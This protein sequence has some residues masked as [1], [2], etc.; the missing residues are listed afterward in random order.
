MGLAPS[1]ETEIYVNTLDQ[2]EGRVCRSVGSFLEPL[3]WS[4]RLF[5]W[6]LVE[7]NV[8]FLL[9][10]RW[11]HFYLSSGEGSLE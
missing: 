1:S 4:S 8:Y 11:G 2:A 7:R 9:D 6:T 5:P 3:M 10:V